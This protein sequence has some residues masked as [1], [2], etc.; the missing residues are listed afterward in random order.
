MSKIS[1]F[2]QPS[3][4]TIQSLETGGAGISSS[5]GPANVL[6]LRSDAQ[7]WS[8]SGGQVSLKSLGANTILSARELRIVQ[9]IEVRFIQHDREVICPNVYSMEQCSTEDNG[10]RTHPNMLED[11][12][13]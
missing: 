7:M 6:R 8:T 3:T 5:F 13:I 1:D 12:T 10:G 2:H 4:V 9:P 11:N